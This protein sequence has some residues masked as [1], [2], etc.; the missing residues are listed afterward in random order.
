MQNRHDNE[1]KFTRRAATAVLLGSFAALTAS[2]AYAQ[3]PPP[4][5]IKGKIYPKA[6]DDRT[7]ASRIIQLNPGQKKVD[8]KVLKTAPTIQQYAKIQAK[9]PKAR[10]F[11]RQISPAPQ[12]PIGKSAG[13][14]RPGAPVKPSSTPVK[15]KK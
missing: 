2:G 6:K 5:P 11:Q 9:K 10:P 15:P 7:P 8:P 1:I 13:V 4:P 12:L 3:K 14:V